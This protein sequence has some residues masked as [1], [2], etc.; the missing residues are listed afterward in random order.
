MGGKDNLFLPPPGCSRFYMTQYTGSSPH[1]RD[2][3]RKFSSLPVFFISCDVCGGGKIRPVVLP[4]SVCP[5]GRFFTPASASQ[6]RVGRKMAETERS[7]T[8]EFRALNRYGA[9]ALSGSE[10]IRR[11]ANALSVRS[12]RWRKFVRGM[13]LRSLNVCLN[14]EIVSLLMRK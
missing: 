5:F 7:C 14:R 3:F 8:L 13:I 4:A 11:T 12:T 6:T 2:L 10:R 9:C 1:P